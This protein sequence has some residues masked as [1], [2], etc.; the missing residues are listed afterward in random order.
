MNGQ[1]IPLPILKG[2]LDLNTH[3]TK[4]LQSLHERMH[5]K[6]HQAYFVVSAG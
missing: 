2:A 1:N 4:V 5:R 3:S 6:Q